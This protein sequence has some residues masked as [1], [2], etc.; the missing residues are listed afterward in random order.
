MTS[1]GYFLFG[2]VFGYAVGSAIDTVIT[3]F[4]KSEEELNEERRALEKALMMSGAI[5]KVLEERENK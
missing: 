3:G 1:I 4:G 2:I 5:E